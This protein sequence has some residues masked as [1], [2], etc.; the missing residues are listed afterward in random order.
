MRAAK[1]KRDRDSRL[2]PSL[3]VYEEVRSDC[4]KLCVGFVPVVDF[5]DLGLV[6]HGPMVTK[7]A[8]VLGEGRDGCRHDQCR[9][10]ARRSLDVPWTLRRT[11]ATKYIPS[12]HTIPERT[13][14]V[15]VQYT[16]PGARSLFCVLLDGEEPEWPSFTKSS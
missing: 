4:P 15:P 3:V 11:P 14:D 9:L 13:T 6:Y 10:I 12:P 5:K 1:Q 7:Y 2:L 8:F 16:R